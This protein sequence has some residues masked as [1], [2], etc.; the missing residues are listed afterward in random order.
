MNTIDIVIGLIL[1]L[2]FYA[3]FKRGLLQTLAALIGLV[4]GIYCA[5][6]FSHFVGSYIAT[7]FDWSEST[8][9]WTAFAITFLAVVLLAN[10]IGKI[11]TKIINLV[12]LGLLN[13]LLGGVFSVLQYAIILSFIFLFFSAE[14]FSGYLI[15]EEKK[16]NSK[17]FA[18]IAS[19]A[20]MILPQL[21]EKF[22]EI[23]LPD[24]API[25]SEESSG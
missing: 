6:H 25:P 8:T 15:S 5:F 2:A 17:L 4:V 7:W 14:N 3:G 19:L 18:P 21:I 1:A 20:P 22:E 12:A 23:P 16:E 11:V 10:L 9:R 24:E 13:K